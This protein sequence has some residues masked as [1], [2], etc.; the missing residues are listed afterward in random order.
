MTSSNDVWKWPAGPFFLF[1]V[2]NFH[3][4]IIE[5]DN[6]IRAPDPT[7]VPALK[8]RWKFRAKQHSPPPI[9]ICAQSIYLKRFRSKDENGRTKREISFFGCSVS[10]FLPIIDGRTG[11]WCRFSSFCVS[12]RPFGNHKRG[13]RVQRLLFHSRQSGDMG[14]PAGRKNTKTKKK[15]GP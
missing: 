1:S 2:T 9:I 12:S 13:D 8:D 10:F 7:P 14:R 5:T 3:P 6:C 4:K 11:G 15:G